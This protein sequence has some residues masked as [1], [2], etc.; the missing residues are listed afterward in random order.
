M[1]QVAPS[2]LSAD[3]LNLAAS[4]AQ[5][6]QAGADWLHIDVMDGHFVP[7][8][9]FGPAIARAIIGQT[10][11]P[12]EVH[13]MVER[14]EDLLQDFL[15]AR[16]SAI[17]LHVE[18]SHHLHRLMQRV[19]ASGV[20]AGLAINPG[21]AWETVTPL[22]PVVDYVLIMTVNPG[23]GG[24]PFIAEMLP[25]ISSLHRHLLGLR[26]EIPIWV[27]GGVGLGN[28]AALQAAGAQVLVTGSAFFGAAN[29][30]EFVQQL[31]AIG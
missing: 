11:L 12:T 4:I 14:P 29:P 15:E 3:W 6:E 22:L 24:Q 30:P 21:T 16:P 23:F 2:M 13:L 7:N 25:K 9:S 1:L 19:Q 31:K 27:D 20:Q 28:A 5:A 26:R 17:S 10:S 18:S 8:L